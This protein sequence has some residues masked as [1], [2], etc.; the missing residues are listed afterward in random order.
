VLVGAYELR[1]IIILDIGFRLA[2]LGTFFGGTK[3][4]FSNQPGYNHYGVKV[5]E[6]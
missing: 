1:V 3:L 2:R 6:S 5:K 4:S